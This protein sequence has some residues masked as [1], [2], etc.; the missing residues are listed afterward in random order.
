M[1]EAAYLSDRVLVMDTHPGRVK[2]MID[3]PLERPRKPSVRQSPVF[4]DLTTRMWHLLRGM[5]GES[6][7]VAPE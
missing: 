4:T 7:E 3:I 2:E 1:D 5:V 6:D